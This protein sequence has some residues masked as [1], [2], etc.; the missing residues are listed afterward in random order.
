M[1]GFLVLATSCGLSET[2]WPEHIAEHEV[3]RSLGTL[4]AVAARKQ[5]AED[6]PRLFTSA[7]EFESWAGGAQRPV[8][9]LGDPV[10]LT[11]VDFGTEVV[12][13]DVVDT[14]DAA[15]AFISEEPG[16]TRSRLYDPTPDDS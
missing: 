13:A 7:E 11:G 1:C 8:H 3:G 9:D 16:E 10:D 12:I 14:C 2:N 6:A 15:Q 4:E 5:L